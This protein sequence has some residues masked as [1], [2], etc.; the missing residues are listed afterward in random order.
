MHEHH[1]V[2]ML[3]GHSPLPTAIRH[4]QHLWSAGLSRQQLQG[5]AGGAKHLVAAAALRA[6]GAVVRE[7]LQHRFASA[8]DVSLLSDIPLRRERQRG[9][10][11]TRS[12]Q[13]GDQRRSLE[14]FDNARQKLRELKLRAP[15]S[16]QVQNDTDGSQAISIRFRRGR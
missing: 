12:G 5:Q 3:Q 14:A 11:A 13:D 4:Q 7:A 15:H 10:L 9:Q 1:R 6:A 16:P 8:I 2:A